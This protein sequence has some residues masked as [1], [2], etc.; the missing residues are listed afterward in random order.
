MNL[1]CVG[2]KVCCRLF[3]L[4]VLVLACCPTPLSPSATPYRVF[5][6]F[7]FP[8]LRWFSS[9]ILASH[10]N[11]FVRSPHLTLLEK[12]N[13]NSTT[14]YTYNLQQVNVQKEIS[15]CACLSACLLAL[16]AC[17]ACLLQADI[18]YHVSV[19]LATN[20]ISAL[21]A[22]ARMSEQ[23]AQNIHI[24][25]HTPISSLPTGTDARV[26][27]EVGYIIRLRRYWFGSDTGCPV[28]HSRIL[29]GGG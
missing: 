28:L 10:F 2:H 25:V 7:F 13:A 20:F 14:K 11:V 27:G 1:V 9:L 16:L 21:D 15:E 24:N 18:S 19:S 23:S 17:L 8:T 22:A 6:C 26:V 5:V 29:C 4:L 3:P 12:E